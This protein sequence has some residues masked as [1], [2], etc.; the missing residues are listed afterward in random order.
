LE[1]A[2][3]AYRQ[4]LALR[5]AVGSQVLIAEAQWAIADTYRLVGNWLKAAEHAEKAGEAWRQVV[6]PWGARHEPAGTEGSP[7]RQEPST[8]A[9][10]STKGTGDDA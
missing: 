7:G 9:Q 10:P 2:L 1:Q 4:S 5:T 3:V 8:A 6:R